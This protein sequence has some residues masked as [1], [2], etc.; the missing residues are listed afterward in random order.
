MSELDADVE[1]FRSGALGAALRAD[2][3]RAH[4]GEVLL[5]IETAGG[6]LCFDHLVAE[7]PAEFFKLIRVLPPRE[8][9]AVISYYV[10]GLPQTAIANVLGVTQ[11]AIKGQLH[12]AACRL[13]G[14]Q[15]KFWRCAEDDV[16]YRTD[17]NCLGQFRVRCEDV[18]AVFSSR[19][20]IRTSGDYDYPT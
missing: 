19:S 16:I 13:W 15:R 6:V 14:E 3:E 18:E 9:F 8:R 12:M 2:L 20:N 7:H 17:P 1:E 11:S 5:S 10:L 4:R